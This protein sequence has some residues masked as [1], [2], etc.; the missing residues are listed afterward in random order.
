M[1]PNDNIARCREAAGLSYGDLARRLG[2]PS[3][4]WWRMETGRIRILAAEMPLIAR[5]LDTTVSA[6]YGELA[7]VR[8]HRRPMR[9]P[10]RA[11]RKA[12]R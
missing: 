6:L 4:Q 10:K 11:R 3:R 7:N 12:R 5:A 8:P 1:T 2:I 9:G